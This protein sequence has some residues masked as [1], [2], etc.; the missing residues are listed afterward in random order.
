MVRNV[1]DEDD[2]GSASIAKQKEKKRKEKRP[3]LF[4]VYASIIHIRRGTHEYQCSS[5]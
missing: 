5:G 2:M 3:L 4:F 1:T